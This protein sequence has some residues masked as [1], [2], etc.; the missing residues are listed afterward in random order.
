LSSLG[1]SERDGT[2]LHILR[3]ALWAGEDS[4]FA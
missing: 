1:S 3:D 4:P 2:S